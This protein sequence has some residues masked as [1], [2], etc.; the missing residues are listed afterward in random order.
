MAVLAASC[1]LIQGEMIGNTQPFVVKT[2]AASCF[3][4][5]FELSCVAWSTALNCQ[6]LNQIHGSNWTRMKIALIEPF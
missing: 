3:V 1:L 5:S 4:S 6:D 2:D